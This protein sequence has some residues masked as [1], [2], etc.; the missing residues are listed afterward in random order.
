MLF[1]KVKPTVTPE[2]REWIENAFLWFENEY[3][4]DFLKSVRIVEP[5]R[6]F[7]DYRFTQSKEDAFYT[8][9][10]ACEIMGIDSQLVELYF[11]NDAPMDFQ[12]EGVFATYNP[13]GAEAKDGYTLG[14]YSESETEKFR[15]GV[16]Q[17]LLQNP[18][19]LISTIAHELSHFKLLGEN[20]IEENDEELTDLNVIVFGFGIFLSN[21]I[22]NFQQWQGTSFGGW[23]ANRSG[24]I[25]EQV[26][27]YAMALLQNYQ[28]TEDTWSKYLKESVRKMY[29]R[30]L[31]YL[32]KTKDEVKFK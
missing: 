20:R 32:R 29:N 24:Y 13:D 5:T 6:A 11:F 22:F 1:G 31:R 17:Q 2:D 26:A 7:F 12:E 25:P 27:T 23:Q 15:I 4:S 16:E 18:E 30:N 21:S 9:E 10:K 8:L 14:L 28:G 19:S 3:G